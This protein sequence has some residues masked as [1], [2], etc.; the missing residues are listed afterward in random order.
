MGPHTRSRHRRSV[1]GS[2]LQ[3]R[4]NPNQDRT[5]ATASDSGSSRKKRDAVTDASITEAPHCSTGRTV[6]R[7]DLN[8]HFSASASVSMPG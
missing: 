3:S 6:A 8:L 1:T 4:L 2:L 5:V 7:F